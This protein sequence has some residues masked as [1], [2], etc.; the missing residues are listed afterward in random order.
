MS[1][2]RNTSGFVM[3]LTLMIIAIGVIVVNQFSY[4]G[5]LHLRF[6]QIQIDQEKATLLAWSA[7]QI[8]ICQLH[9][10]KEDGINKKSTEKTEKKEDPYAVF[11]K[12]IFPV[13]NQFQTFNLKEN[14]DGITGTI[15]LCI[16]SED[17]KLNLNQLYN[18]ENHSFAIPEIPKATSDKVF[19]YIFDQIKKESRVPLFTGFENFLKERSFECNDATELLIIPE[20][21]TMFSKN[22]I[23]TPTQSTQD[24]TKKRIF[25]L[26]DMFT[27]WSEKPTLDPF[28]LS[29]A[30][31]TILGLQF[32]NSGLNELLKDFTRDPQP[33]QQLWDTKLKKL[34]GKEFKA[35][36][37]EIT[38]LFSTKFEPSTFSVLCYATVGNVTQRLYVILRRTQ[39]YEMLRDEFDIVKVYW[40]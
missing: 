25:Y 10:E 13:L 19:T 4:R 5:S 39:S 27:T 9:I 17:G 16:T 2:Q 38:D 14:I 21:N 11:A 24:G 22:V 26:C 3:V 20:F 23:Y 37:K 32:D 28:L 6:N 15:K 36:P 1:R 12:R 7:V 30:I 40:L 35:L 31:Q 29:P 34:Y 18:F 8:A 33:L